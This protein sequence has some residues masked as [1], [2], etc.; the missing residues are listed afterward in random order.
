MTATALSTVS[1]LGIAAADHHI[2]VR[3]N[4]AADRFYARCTCG[5]SALDVIHPDTAARIGREHVDKIADV[6]KRVAGRHRDGHHAVVVAAGGRITVACSCEGFRITEKK[7]DQ[8]VAAWGRHLDACPPAE[9]ATAAGK[10]A[11]RCPTPG[12]VGFNSRRSAEKGLERF[13]RT[14]RGKKAPVRCYKC[15]CGRWHHTSK[16]KAAGVPR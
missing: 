13:W 16:P 14:F 12:K 2:E 6:D 15:P 5:W 10:R 3:E 9:Q 4:F 7:A 1:G 8:V 11:R